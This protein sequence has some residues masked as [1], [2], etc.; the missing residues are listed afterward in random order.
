MKVLE[1]M[2]KGLE[3]YKDEAILVARLGLG[4]MFVYVHGGPKV[5]GGPKKWLEV[6]SMLK[7]IGITAAPQ[8]LGLIAGLYEFIGGILIG[9]GLF[10][11]FGAGLILSNLLIA[12]A[13]MYQLKGLFG[14]APALEDALF[15]LVLLAIGAGR[16]SLDYKWFK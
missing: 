16:Y 11:R 15:M 10:T 9:L 3:D 13:V 8:I 6:G 7:V 1:I 2:Q 5:L 12:V 14:A 4:F